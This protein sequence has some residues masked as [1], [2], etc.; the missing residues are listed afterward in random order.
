MDERLLARLVTETMRQTPL[1]VGTTGFHFRRHLAKWPVCYGQGH[2]IGADLV[3]FTIQGQLLDIPL[4]FGPARFLVGG[5]GECS[6]EDD[7]AF[8][9][10]LAPL[11]GEV[12]RFYICVADDGHAWMVFWEEAQAPGLVAHLRALHAAPDLRSAA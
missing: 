3:R 8:F 11:T 5:Q 9:Q 2:F 4:G 7:P 10:A 6:L 1:T 12:D